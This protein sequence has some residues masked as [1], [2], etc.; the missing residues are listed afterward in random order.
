MILIKPIEFFHGKY[1]AFGKVVDG[2]EVLDIV[3]QT[4]TSFEIPDLPIIVSDARII[5]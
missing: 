4:S 3:S 2:L 1:V 5:Q